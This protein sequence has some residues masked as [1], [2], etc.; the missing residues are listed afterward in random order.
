M[1]TIKQE[2]HGKDKDDSKHSSRSDT[3]FI[4]RR[5]AQPRQAQVRALVRASARAQRIGVKNIEGRIC[6]SAFKIKKLL[7][8]P[9]A[10]EVKK[11]RSRCS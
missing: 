5:A 1:L 11:K 10:I 3:V 9:K 4:A 8:Q 2:K 7:A 6:N